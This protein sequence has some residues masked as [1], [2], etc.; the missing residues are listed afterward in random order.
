[1]NETTEVDA[2]TLILAVVLAM[3]VA[4]YD[5]STGPGTATRRAGLDRRI[6]WFTGPQDWDAHCQFESAMR[7]ALAA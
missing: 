4:R 2:G 6:R 1:M 3:F 7:A 5:G